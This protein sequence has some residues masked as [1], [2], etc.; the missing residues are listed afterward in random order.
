[1][2]LAL[3]TRQNKYPSHSVRIL[4]NVYRTLH[5]AEGCLGCAHAQQMIW[6]LLNAVEKGFTASGDTDKAF[7]T[8]MPDFTRKFWLLILANRG[9]GKARANGQGATYWVVGPTS[10]LA[11]VLLATKQ[12]SY[13]A[14]R[15]M[16]S[17]QRLARRYPS[18]SFSSRWLIPR[19]L[20]RR[21]RC[22]Q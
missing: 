19:L 22:C 5:T 13:L 14:L 15:R 12:W 4:N 8:G 3:V 18:P 9:Q 1:M 11:I 7:L 17:R 16:E 10:R 6:E 20:Y 21:V 2:W